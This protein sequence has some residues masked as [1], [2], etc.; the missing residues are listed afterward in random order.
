MSLLKIHLSLA[1]YVR[2]KFNKHF[3]VWI[4]DILTVHWLYIEEEL[5]FLLQRP[6][7]L[8]PAYC[9]VKHKSIHW[10]IFQSDIFCS[11]GTNLL[12]SLRNTSFKINCLS[13]QLDFQWQKIISNI[14]MRFPLSPPSLRDAV[15]FIL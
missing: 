1:F 9:R 7:S 2:Q 15:Y 13:Q 3:A 6:A 10:A 8:T 14:H 5:S 11:N 12:Y 4:S